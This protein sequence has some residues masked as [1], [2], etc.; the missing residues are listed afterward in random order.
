VA[1]TLIELDADE[2]RQLIRVQALGNGSASSPDFRLR[3][4]TVDMYMEN[5]VISRA[6]AHGDSGATMTS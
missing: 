2:D 5:K 4:D 6:L 3:S 1:G